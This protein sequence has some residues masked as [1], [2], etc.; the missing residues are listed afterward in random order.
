MTNNF[1]FLS[2][3]SFLPTMAF[4]LSI[5]TTS[6]VT[7]FAFPFFL[8]F[9]CLRILKS[10][11]K[12]KN[13]P[14]K[15]GG[16]WPVI[17][18]L[19]LLSGPQPAH[20]TLGLMSDKYGPIFT[21]NLG[22]HRALV[23]CNPEIA[24]E[25]L[26]THDKVFATRPKTLATEILGY[27]QT[28]FG[29]IPYGPYWRQIRKMATLELLSTHRLETLKNVRQSEVKTSIKE[30]YQLWEE[31]KSTDRNQVLVDMR[32]WFGDVTLN[33][34]FRMIVGRRY[35]GDGQESGGWKLAL[36][37]FF[38]LSGKFVVA[39]ALPF[40]RWLDL[41]G[42]EKA[43]KKT[44]K[45]L[46]YV[47]EEWLEEHKKKKRSGG[48]RVDE[49]DFMDVMLSV[50]DHENDPPAGHSAHTTNK[51]TCLA[52]I[53]AASDT[54]MVTLTW[55]LSL[56]LNNCDVLNKAQHELDSH[57]G[58]ERPV[59]ESDTKSL[60]YLEAIIKET[61]RL[62][63]AGP[64]LIP[65]E[66]MED[67]SVAGYHVP[68]G[69]RLLVDVWKIHRDPHVWEEPHEFRPERFLTTHKDVDVKGHNFE[70]IPFGSG[71][72]M[73]PGVLFALQVL[74]LTLANLL[75]GFDFATPNDEPVDMTES[76]GLTILKETPLEALVSPRLQGH[77]YMDGTS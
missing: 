39:D 51:S 49:E 12:N 13:T 57:V 34:I 53:L 4:L 19:H 66:S 28:M 72:R 9:L 33:V 55:A 16:A 40:L 7:I 45:E 27:D 60:R 73:C 64:L 76:S 63:P 35:I 77:L 15:A 48:G 6:I 46:D 58:R 10:E 74:Q 44:A 54:T 67:C 25:C 20:R 30:L 14:P 37:E 21:I 50:L 71:R 56:L 32:R 23:V 3:S 43:M 47:V 65:H 38:E 69:T 24:K 18:H 29:F 26:T 41:G 2:T 8:Y 70:L 36:R 52:L 5:S 31:N 22:I 61:L 62:Y 59:N 17:G 11:S 75:H 1:L 68:A 42:D